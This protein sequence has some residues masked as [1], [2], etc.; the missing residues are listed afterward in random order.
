MCLM[1]Y[2]K[3]PVLVNLKADQQKVFNLK[4]HIK[5]YG[6]IEIHVKQY[7]VISHTC[8]RR[9]RRRGKKE[10]EVYLVNSG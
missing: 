9:L 8:N 7:E 4:K 6:Y 10:A 3:R 5:K 1:T 2:I